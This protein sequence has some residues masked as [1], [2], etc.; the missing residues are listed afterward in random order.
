M[1]DERPQYGE[2]ASEDEQRRRAGLPPLDPATADLPPAGYGPAA[3]P[4][5]EEPTIP[6]RRWGPDRIATIALLAYGLVNVLMSAGSYLDLST[7]MNQYM[8]ILGIEGEFTNLAQGRLWGG[9]AATVLVAGYALTVWLS[10]RRLR[11]RKL[12]WWVPVVGAIVTSFAV[13]LC[14]IV[15]MMGDPVFA[16]FLGATTS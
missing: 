8:A 11:A 2:Y 12:T 15:P 3:V 10:L 7:I 4:A 14:L 13:S 5:V 1:S 16:S 6:A 9:I